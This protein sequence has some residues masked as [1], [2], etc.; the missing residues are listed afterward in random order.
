MKRKELFL[1]QNIS[2]NISITVTFSQ[3]KNN[4]KFVP[5]KEKKLKKKICLQTLYS[6]K[7]KYYLNKKCICS[8]IFQLISSKHGYSLSSFF[9]DVVKVR[10]EHGFLF[11]RHR[12]FLNDF[13]KLYV[14]FFNKKNYLSWLLNFMHRANRT[15]RPSYRTANCKDV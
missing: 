9:G 3:L 5:M 2:N 1:L 15:C 10:F 7:N 8:M 13:V 6:H 14:E 12:G 4:Q 11:L